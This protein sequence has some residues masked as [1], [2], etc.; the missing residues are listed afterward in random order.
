M[1]NRANTLF[2]FLFLIISLISCSKN[3]KKK[4]TTRGGCPAFNSDE[5]QIRSINWNCGDSGSIFNQGS[6]KIAF[7]GKGND[8]YIRG[9]N[10]RSKH[11]YTLIFG[12]WHNSKTRFLYNGKV[13]GNCEGITQ[14]SSDT[15]YSYVVTIDG[16]TGQIQIDR[17]NG[18]HQS[19]FNK[20][21]YKS[22]G[23]WQTVF[24]CAPGSSNLLQAV[25][26]SMSCYCKKPSDTVVT[27]YNYRTFAVNPGYPIFDLPKN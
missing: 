6:A 12:G 5:F 1:F 21:A 27:I 7:L 11:I 15:V 25:S 10:N 16:P 23:G 8:W 3:L 20:N 17:D 24:K 19:Q 26:Y 9:F 2:V 22:P 13:V 14:I 4:I 18:V